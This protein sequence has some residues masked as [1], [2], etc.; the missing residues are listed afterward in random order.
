MRKLVFLTLLGLALPI[1]TW[2]NSVPVV[3]TNSGGKLTTNGTTI[4]LTGA[5][6]TSFSGLGMS[7]TGSLGSLT[8]TSGALSGGS[9]GTTGNF[10]AG[11]TF[12]VTSNGTGGLPNGPLFTGTFSGSANWVGTY[13]PLGNGGKGN[14]TYTFKGPISGM[15][16]NG[17]AANG[18]TV[19]LSFDVPN[20][21]KFG[22]G[23][24]ARG[25]HGSSTVVAT[26]EPGSLILLGTGLFAVAG[27]LRRKHPAL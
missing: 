24:P 17:V 3:F 4:T 12:T 16:Y 20:S 1:A 18:G 2:A 22:V 21:F 7:L 19:Q 11:G 8:F 9:L 26:P 25:N 6:L 15:F 5:T 10:A 14:W 27:L 23:H 13:N